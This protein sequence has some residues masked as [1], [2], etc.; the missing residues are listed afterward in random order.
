MIVLHQGMTENE[1]IEAIDFSF[2]FD[3]DSEYEEATRLACSISDNAVLMV[4]YELATLS[5]HASTEVG[6]RLLQIMKSE[7]PTP[8]ILAAIPVVDALIKK[9]K[10]QQEEVQ[11]LL[12]ACQNHDNAWNG[13]GIV[14]CADH[15]LAGECDKIRDSWS[16]ANS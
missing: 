7:R 13:L 6:L 11:R 5:S 9:R 14:E 8:V 3:K 4:G 15:A 1:F 2:H 16:K 10:V 12:E